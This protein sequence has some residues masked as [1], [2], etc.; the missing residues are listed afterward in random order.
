MLKG[1]C[2]G[3]QGARQSHKI[4]RLADSEP[5]EIAPNEIGEVSGGIQEERLVLGAPLN[6]GTTAIAKKILS[7]DKLYDIV[8]LS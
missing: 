2:A 3:D 6:Q 7:P 1:D 8:H 5:I 4:S